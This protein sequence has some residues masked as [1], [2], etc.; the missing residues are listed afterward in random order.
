M[1][2]SCFVWKAENYLK[3]KLY[4]LV[5]SCYMLRISDGRFI[6]QN[7]R[8]LSESYKVLCKF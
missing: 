7:K 3:Y 6:F 8:K 1:V 2:V 4:C 5:A